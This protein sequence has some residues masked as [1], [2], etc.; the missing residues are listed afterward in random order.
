MRVIEDLQARGL[1][2]EM[3]ASSGDNAQFDCPFPENHG[4]RTRGGKPHFGI[5]LVDAPGKSAG[6]YHCFSCHAGGRDI[7]TLWSRLTGETVKRAKEEL[8][9]TEVLIDTVFKAVRALDDE[10]NTKP[11]C[12][13]DWPQT[14]SVYQSPVAMEYLRGRNIPESLWDLAGLEWFGGATMPPRKDKDK[15]S[16]RGSRLIIPLDWA[17]RRIGYSSRAVGYDTDLRY[18]RPV[19]NLNHLVYDPSHLVARGIR[20]RVWVVEGEVDCWAG[21][22]EGLPTVSTLG[23]AVT[24]K[25]A[26]ILAGFK[27]VCFLYDSDHAGYGG[28]R[29]VSELFGGMLNWRAFWLPEGQD[30]GGMAP[31]WGA[32]VKAL[33]DRPAPD[34]SLISLAKAVKGI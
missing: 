7:W 24:R 13:T 10:V 33:A 27:E 3:R 23:S 32:A 15:S 20:D 21:L 4:G 9:A 31:G 29:R 2:G 1:L 16:V 5:R 14:V 28:V 6:S 18:Y 25:Q 8:S 11:V 22:R 30:P 12:L 34:H 19:Q 17:G 26:Q